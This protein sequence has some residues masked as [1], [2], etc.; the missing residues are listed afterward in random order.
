MPKLTVAATLTYGDTTPDGSVPCREPLSFTFDYTEQSIKTVQI[1][2]STTDF[3]I[4]VDTV[5]AP[6]FLFAKSETTDVTIKLSDG[7]V[8]TPTPSA[9]S[10]EGGWIMLANPN[11]QVIKTI[12]VTTPAS[13]TA[14]ARVKVIAFE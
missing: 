11:G 1:P 3:A 5:G 6:K 14:G 9:L 4:N 13:P 10:E 2:A 12:L 7:V 8:V